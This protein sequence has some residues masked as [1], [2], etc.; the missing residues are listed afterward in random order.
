MKSNLDINIRGLQPNEPIPYS[1]LLLADPSRTVVDTYIDRGQVYVAVI[2]QTI[3]GVMVLLDTRPGTIEI[4]NIAVAEEWQSRGIGKALLQHAVFQ[5]RQQ[6]A[7]TLE[8]GTG[9]SSLT[10]LGLYQRMGFRMTGIDRDF[11][12]RHYEEKIVENGI[13]CVDMIRLAMEL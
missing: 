8:I 4:V 1:M 12:T 10:Q 2:V 13:P 3:V 7:S 9:N 6:G 5:G 11:F